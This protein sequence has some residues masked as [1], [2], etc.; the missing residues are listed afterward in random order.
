MS[1]SVGMPVSFVP[2]PDNEFDPNAIK[3][4]VHRGGGPPTT[5][6]GAEHVG[7]V[8]RELCVVFKEMLDRD[9]CWGPRVYRVWNKRGQEGQGV[10]VVFHSDI[11]LPRADRKRTKVETGYF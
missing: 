1:V 2:E 11:L 6:E 4:M 9:A 7:Y 10:C 3:V 8:P 5:L